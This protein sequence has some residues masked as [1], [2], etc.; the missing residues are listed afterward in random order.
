MSTLEIGK[1]ARAH[2]I[3]GELKVRP[4]FAGSDSLR[5]VPK[6]SLKP[7]CGQAR[8]YEVMSVR[9]SPGEPILAL[10][11]VSSRN[12]ADELRGH[13]VVVERKYLP[14][15]EPGE[16]FLVDLVGCRVECSG[17]TLGKVV[18]VRPD[19]TVDTLVIELGAGGLAEQPVADTW[20][21]RVDVKAGLV[22]LENEDGLITD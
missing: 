18:E 7:P 1:I 15:L 11:G 10:S 4:H 13:S 3:R 14:P 20:I 9:G 21:R 19:M 2:G 6:L 16:Y 12:A 22:E 17:K 8:E 5:H